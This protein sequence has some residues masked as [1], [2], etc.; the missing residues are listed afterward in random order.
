MCLRD[1]SKE[2]DLASGL[3]TE[4]KTPTEELPDRI[5]QLTERLRAAEK[6]IEA[7]RRQ[8]LLSN[9]AEL[10]GRAEPVGGFKLVAKQLPDGI[11]AGDLRTIA[12]DLRGK[13]QGEAAVVVLAS[14]DGGK[15][16]FAVSATP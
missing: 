13:L 12:N 7:M 1:S 8:Q 5:A 6:G 14:N 16:P 4:L 9:T 3:A 11:A 15:V 10:A 2:A